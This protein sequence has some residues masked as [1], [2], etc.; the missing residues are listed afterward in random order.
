MVNIPSC[1]YCVCMCVCVLAAPLCV[2]L[3]DLIDCSLPGSPVHG[4]HQQEYWSGLPFLCPVD[5]PY[6]GLLHCRHILYHL[7]M[8]SLEKCMFESLAQF[9]FLL[10]LLFVFL[11][12]SCISCLYILEIT[13]SVVSFAIIF[14]HSEDCLFTLFFAVQKLLNL[15]GS[16]LFIFV[17]ISIILKGGS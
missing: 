5:L 7:S 8:F 9:F 16:H 15:I 14:S 10:L 3:C 6:P 12:L 1:V 13:L 17:F 11:V 4:I 2:I